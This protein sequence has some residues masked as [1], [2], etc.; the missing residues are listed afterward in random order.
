MFHVGVER[1]AFNWGKNIGEVDGEEGAEGKEE[2]WLEAIA[3]FVHFKKYILLMKSRRLIWV[4][5]VESTGEKRNLQ[6][7]DGKIWK[8]GISY[9]NLA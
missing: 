3:L 1:C 9:K 8:K 2:K 6:N 5:H 4:G 7:F